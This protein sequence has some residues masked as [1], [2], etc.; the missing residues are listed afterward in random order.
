MAEVHEVVNRAA[1]LHDA[2]AAG[3]A[4]AGGVLRCG[5]CGAERPLGDVARYLSRGWPG[6]CGATM[7][8]VTTRTILAER[9]TIPD[10]HE[11]V[12]VASSG[13]RVEPGKL[14]VG[15]A[16][17]LTCRK[18]SAAELNRRQHRTRGTLQPGWVDAWWPYCLEHTAGY[19]HWIEGGQ[20]M[21]WILRET[22]AN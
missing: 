9:R 5:A 15:K 1:G 17:R 18:P 2:A 6:H 22:R 11:L 10:G 8:W 21:H 14:C 4:L 3:L 12:A 13:W 7:T 16:R 19:G 20:V